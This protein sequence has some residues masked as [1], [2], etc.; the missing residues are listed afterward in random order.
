MSIRIAIAGGGISG[1]SLAYALLDKNPALDVTVYEADSRP[2]GKVYTER[3]DGYICEAGVNGF[4]DNKPATLELA[5]KIG[6]PPIKSNDNARKRYIY[7][8]GALRM[9][10]TD[11]A[12]FFLSNFLTLGG[13]LRMMGEYFVPKKNYEDESLKDF[14]V[15]RVG[16][17]FYEKL[18]DPMASG[19]YAG[20]PEKMSIR[21]CFGKVY[22]LEQKYGGLIKG[23]MAVAKEKKQTGESSKVE[24]GP[25]GTLMSFEQGM[26]SL[27]QALSDFLGERLVT[28]KR[29]VETEKSTHG[30]TLHFA[31]GTQADSDC[32]VITAPAHDMAG[33]IKGIDSSIAMQLNDIPYPALSVV[34]FG[35]RKERLTRDLNLFGFL[36][37]AKE[38]R[39]ILGTLF[40]TSIFPNRAPQD[41]VLL[42]VMIG[43]AR[44]EER[45]LLPDEKLIDVARSELAAIADVKADPELIKVYRWEKAIPQYHVNHHKRIEMIEAA[46]IRHKGLYLGGNA[47]RGVAVNDCI[48]NGYRLADQIIADMD[49]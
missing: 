12:K 19:I 3:V 35:Y 36:I 37:P 24:A 40:D 33:A 29:L 10:P 21:S 25:G 26:Y 22:D 44:A 31:D 6:L 43:G 30:Y 9:I 41:H 18:L 17:E 39:Q 20:D 4:L 7:F 11:P 13:R 1:L 45:A 28:G 47:F 48:G 14:A 5:K 27:I 8:D 38:K 46:L 2:G 16:A 42:R 32:V 15:R 23:F 34:A 49:K